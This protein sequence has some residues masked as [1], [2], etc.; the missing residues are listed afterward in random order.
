M[1]KS[2]SDQIM[3]ICRV[4]FPPTRIISLVP[5][6]TE[7]LYALQLHD[8]IIGISDFCPSLTGH[9]CRI[10]GPK[11]PDMKKIR[12]LQPDLILA[13]KEE[14]KKEDILKLSEYQAVWTSDVHTIQDALELISQLGTVCNREEEASQ[15]REE[16]ETQFQGLCEKA[17]P[18]VY[19]IWK[20]PWYFVGGDTFI[21]A[22]MDT[23]GF[24]NMLVE[25]KR[26]PVCTWD[27]DHI[28]S[29]EL[30]L[31]SSEPFPFHYKDVLSLRSQ[32]PHKKVYLI[33]GE[34]F[35]WYGARMKYAPHYIRA[36]R[37]ILQKESD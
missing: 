8:H 4:H 26:Y 15:L 11:N 18:S 17:V 31:L 35:S 19:V 37:R 32:F 24:K 3:Q 5:S 25:Y 6:I 27:D 12:E 36:F 9:S 29:A 16:I 30:I 33:R 7:T 23:F 13:S 10:G 20:N 21:H 2:F 34:M 28:A 22:M 1:F 14:N